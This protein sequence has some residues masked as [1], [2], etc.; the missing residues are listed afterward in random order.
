MSHNSGL[1]L[2]FWIKLLSYWLNSELWLGYM[3]CC[4]NGQLRDTSG[5]Y[6]RRALYTRFCLAAFA[7]ARTPQCH[8]FRSH[9][10]F[11]SSVGQSG[12]LV[13]SAGSG[14]GGSSGFGATTFG[15]SGFG[16]LGGVGG[17]SEN[18]GGGAESF[19]FS[20]DGIRGGSSSAFDDDD[21]D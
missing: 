2:G 3:G 12:G 8:H 19:D 9:R 21:E 16:S 15:S 1:L 10:V 17:S 14:A 5:G 13:G 11:V 7:R 4:S 20:S 6:T 18:A